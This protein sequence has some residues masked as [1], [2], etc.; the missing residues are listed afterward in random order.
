MKLKISSYAIPWRILNIISSNIFLNN[1]KQT[2]ILIKKQHNYIQ[3]IFCIPIKFITY[4]R[5]LKLYIFVQNFE[6]GENS[7][8]YI[9]HNLNKFLLPSCLHL[10]SEQFLLKIKFYELRFFFI[11]DEFLGSLRK[12]I[13]KSLCNL[14]YM[15]FQ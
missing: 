2:I 13:I 12:I 15:V 14:I 10:F 4:I 3:F 8:T 5:I 7:C 9:I 6:G 11:L 1:K